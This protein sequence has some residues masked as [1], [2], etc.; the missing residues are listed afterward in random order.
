L[1]VLAISD[2]HLGEETSLLSFPRGLQH[3]WETLRQDPVFW[4]PVFPGFEED[5]MVQVDELV[6]V[7]DVA[8]RTLSSTS[9]ISANSHAFAMMVDSALDV[10]QAVYVPGN[11]DH[12]LWT[13]YLDAARSRRGGSL[14][15]GPMGE[16]IAKGGKCFEG[17]E[18]LLSVFL[19]YPNGW[20]WWT[21][22]QGERPDFVFKVA[23]PLYATQ[24]EGRAYIFAHGTHFRPE[25]VPGWSEGVLKVLDVAQVD[26]L[27]KLE[28]ERIE[29]PRK[30]HD[31]EDLERRVSAFVD[32]LWPSS[33]NKPTSRSDELWFLMTLL[34][35][36][37]GQG[38]RSPERS[39]AY[40]RDRLPEVPEWRLQRLTDEGN[41]PT[42]GSLER[43][44]E[45]F[46]PHLNDH[47]LKEEGLVQD[48]LVFVYGDTHRGGW[49]E[50]VADGW[51][52]P[53]RVYNC[54]AWVV[55]GSHQ[56]PACHLFA[57]REDGEEFLLDVSFDRGPSGE[58]VKVGEDRL[59]SLAAEDAE[60]RR[61][62][63]SANVRALGVTLQMVKDT[64]GRGW[65]QSLKDIL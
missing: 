37:A 7:G 45:V 61:G 32:A 9:Q 24:I 13:G 58:E 44:S 41:R 48:E 29:D 47:L 36:R 64:L 19:G 25:V 26:R 4:E 49:G 18:E 54:G 12:T 16:E 22:K 50:L 20:A 62:A 46:L 59:L 43:F 30:A 51:A 2:T 33:K 35:E 60:H 31:M 3:L 27:L 40:R 8:D 57:V 5:D 63:V 15:T 6:L 14:I 39:E 55:E 21:L 34:R 28:F 52:A 42:D 53:I 1:R 56:H 11:H 38:R 10:K 65:R 23:N 17:A